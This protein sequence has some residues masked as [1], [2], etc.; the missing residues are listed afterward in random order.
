[1][2]K[3][4]TIRERTED[5]ELLLSGNLVMT[6]EAWEQ[7]GGIYHG[8]LGHA[9]RK[10]SFFTVRECE[11]MGFPV[12][13]EEFKNCKDFAMFGDCY[14]YNCIEVG[15]GKKVRPCL[16][17]FYRDKKDIWVKLKSRID[18]FYPD[19]T[20]RGTKWSEPGIYTSLA[21]AEHLIKVTD[22]KFKIAGYMRSN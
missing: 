13:D 22:G 20:S 6:K 8:W 3:T 15:K 18:L 2:G 4:A 21:M 5:K 12:S 16:P 10:E 7:R 19:G 14:A 9:A 11:R 1:M 17:V